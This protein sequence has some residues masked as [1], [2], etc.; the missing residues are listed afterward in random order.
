MSAMDPL[1]IYDYLTLSRGHLFD[2][3]RPL[4]DDQYRREFPIG[5]SSL[6]R[7][8]T[9]VMLC[10]GMYVARLEGRHVPPYSEWPIQDEQPPPFAVVESTWTDQAAHTRSVLAAVDDWN[11]EIQY[12][13]LPD[14]GPQRTITTTPANLVTQ[15]AFHEVHHRAQAL[16]ML[17]HLGVATTDVDFNTLMRND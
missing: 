2:W 5:L 16:N 8:L 11:R 13:T 1:R 4:S 12:Q 15:I 6:A 9:H 7:T 17:R 14:L 3:V 10:E